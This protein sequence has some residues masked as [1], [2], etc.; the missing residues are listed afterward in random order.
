MFVGHTFIL[1]FTSIWYLYSYFSGRC[2]ILHREM[3]EF[4]IK[5]QAEVKKETS[6]C[7]PALAYTS[8][9]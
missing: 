2:I 3:L 6:N 9:M 8:S 4:G 5:P 1:Y 7:N